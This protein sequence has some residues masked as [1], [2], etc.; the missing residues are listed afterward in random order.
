MIAHR[1]SRLP[2]LSKLSAHEIAEFISKTEGA[3][4]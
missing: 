3:Q 1:A 2:D 4:I